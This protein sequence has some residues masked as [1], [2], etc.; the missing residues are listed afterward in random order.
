MQGPRLVI[1]G[2][3]PAR[4]WSRPTA[5]PPS[6]AGPSPRLPG[7]RAPQVPPHRGRRGGSGALRPRGRAPGLRSA[8]V[9]ACPAASPHL[10]IHTALGRV[11]ADIVPT[12]TVPVIAIALI[13][14]ATAT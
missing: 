11:L 5:R 12:D 2:P 14:S 7:P 3:R 9:A 4:P 1:I 10:P 6:R 13:G 8:P